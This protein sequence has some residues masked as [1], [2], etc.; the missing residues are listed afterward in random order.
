MAVR[1]MGMHGC[2]TAVPIVSSVPAV[3]DG[4]ACSAQGPVPPALN[5]PERQGV[6]WVSRIAV[7]VSDSSPAGQLQLDLAEWAAHALSSVSAEKKPWV[8][9]TQAWSAEE[10]PAT[11]PKPRV[12]AGEP[13]GSQASPPPA[14]NLPA[15][16][17]AQEASAEPEP[18][19]ASLPAVQSGRRKTAQ[20]SGPV[21]AFQ[22]PL[23]HAVQWP[24][25]LE[26]PTVSCWP[27]P[28]VV[29]S[30]T[31]QALCDV[32]LLKWPSTQSA[33]LSSFV[34]SPTAKPKPGPQEVCERAAQALP[35]PVEKLLP[36]QAW[37]CAFAVRV[38]ATGSLP[39]EH[40]GT[41]C[42]PHAPAPGPALNVVALQCAHVPSRCALPAVSSSPAGH[43]VMA[44]AAQALSSLAPLQVPAAQEWHDE[45]ATLDVE[46][47]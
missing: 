45:S 14:E 9:A 13:C 27:A 46:R 19:T 36:V 12:Q 8:Q 39:A 10:D 1:Y 33:Q 5:L 18:A 40:P 15:E 35:P 7:P 2:L 41:V 28:Q 38:P 42:G 37:Q 11:W 47:L 23:A 22:Y 4:T 31:R 32:C 3:Q 16:Q 43:V 17:A 20:T 29:V 21:V 30:K 44:C 24:S 34:R 25:E 26:V 6:Q